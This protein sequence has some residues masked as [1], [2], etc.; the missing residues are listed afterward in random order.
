MD[1]GDVASIYRRYLSAEIDREIAPEDQMYVS[2]PDWYFEIGQSGLMCILRALIAA[3]L[4][5]VRSIL[6]VPSGHGRV[7]RHLRA[8]FPEAHLAVCDLDESGVEFC[9]R[10]WNCEPIVSEPDLPTVDLRGPYDVIWV[11]SLFTHVDGPRTRA[12]LRHLVNAVGDGGVLV[13]TWH[14]RWSL[15]VQESYFSMIDEPSWRNIVSAYRQTGYGFAPYENAD[16]YGISL[17]DPAW[18]VDA[19]GAIEGVRL[20]A[21]AERGW[22]DNHDVLVIGKTDRSKPWPNTL[23]S[24]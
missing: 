11:G 20:L 21:Y 7:T 8:A 3:E 10:R 9:A 17:S 12:W 24:S 5:S 2:G 22:A 4:G 14:G 6:D 18:V 19:V 15:I 16:G 23:A 1:L 13:S